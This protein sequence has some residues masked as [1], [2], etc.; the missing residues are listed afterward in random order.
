MKRLDHQDGG[1]TNHIIPVLKTDFLVLFII[2]F[3][4]FSQK[5]PLSR[6]TETI[7]ILIRPVR[8][9]YWLNVLR[10]ETS[11]RVLL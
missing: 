4:L 9:D 10:A 3:E 1:M 8:R 7:A 6:D 5:N 2:I 11:A